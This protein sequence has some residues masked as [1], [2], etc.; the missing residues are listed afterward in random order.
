[1]KKNYLYIIIAALVLFNAY[2]INKVSNI[3]SSMNSNIQQIYSEQNNLRNEINNIYTNV[4]EKLKKQASL[5]DSYDVIFGDELNTDNLT[6]PVNISVTPKENTEN[7][8]AVLLINDERNAMLKIGVFPNGDMAFF[9][10]NGY[11]DMGIVAKEEGYC[12][13]H[14]MSKNLT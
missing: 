1:L 2:T 3:E 8:T 10:R 6:V 11:S 5:L 9:K 4:D 13:L 12:T 7:L 14:M